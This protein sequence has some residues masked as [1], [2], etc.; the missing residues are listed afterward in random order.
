MASAT[1]SSIISTPSFYVKYIRDRY[2]TDPEFRSKLQ[3]RNAA[4]AA[5]VKSDPL[6]RARK[7]ESAR[8][9]Y[10]TH[11]EYRARKCAAARNRHMEFKIHSDSLSSDPDPVV[12]IRQCADP[13]INN[14][15]LAV[16]S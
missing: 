16:K 4:Y 12:P 7:R 10:H 2:H 5:T 6:V 14:V 3:T 9:Y 15:A 11:D 8:R 1:P 13:V